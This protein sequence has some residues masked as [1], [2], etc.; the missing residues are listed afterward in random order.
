MMT[1]DELEKSVVTWLR[2]LQQT[3]SQKWQD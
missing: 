3:D 2:Q 1:I